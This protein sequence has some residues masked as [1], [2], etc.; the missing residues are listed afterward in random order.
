M[1]KNCVSGWSGPSKTT[2]RSGNAGMESA[3]AWNAPCSHMI[4]L[5]S[6]A[7]TTR[8]IAMWFTSS[9]QDGEVGWP[10]EITTFGGSAGLVR[11]SSFW[12]KYKFT[13][14]IEVEINGTGVER[15][16]G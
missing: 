15:T 1:A 7:G 8:P 5:E 13:S 6:S 10:R 14:A 16:L 9:D 12:W 3:S 4:G 11:S 2:L